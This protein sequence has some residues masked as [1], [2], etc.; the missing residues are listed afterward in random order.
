MIRRPDSET[1]SAESDELERLCGRLG[2]VEAPFDEITRSRAEARLVDALAREPARRHWRTLGK[3]GKVGQAAALV[4]MGA[5]AGGGLVA[6]FGGAAR[7][8]VA[9]RG[10]PSLRFEPYVVAPTVPA[11]GS[12]VGSPV[13]EALVRSSSRLDVPTG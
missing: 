3:V 6:R 2:R 12:H 7:S 1:G 8:Q 9:G 10:E 4:L 11:A 13:P 5:A